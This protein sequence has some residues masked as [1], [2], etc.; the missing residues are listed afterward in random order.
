MKATTIT[1]HTA[2][3]FRFIYSRRTEVF[4]VKNKEKVKRIDDVLN[5]PSFDFIL[6]IIA[7][8]V[9]LNISFSFFLS[10]LLIILFYTLF[11]NHT[12]NNHKKILFIVRFYFYDLLRCHSDNHGNTFHE[13]QAEFRY[14]DRSATDQWSCVNRQPL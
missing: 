4:S 9:A 5:W 10:F 3:R 1:L 14:V 6:Y 2:K 11:E 7:L 13:C 12:S 8:D